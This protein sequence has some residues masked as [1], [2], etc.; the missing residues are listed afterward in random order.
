M[1]NQTL[2]KIIS[3]LASIP[4]DSC[5]RLLLQLALA[6]DIP[7]D[8]REQ[9][10]SYKEEKDL[11]ELLKNENFLGQLIE[12]D[13]SIG[14]AEENMLSELIELIGLVVPIEMETKDFLLAELAENVED[15]L[16]ELIASGSIKQTPVIWSN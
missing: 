16:D 12:A 15:E 1:D 13:G 8:R 6:A 9:L 10:L 4:P 5:L 2:R 14:E 11:K 7:E 3:F